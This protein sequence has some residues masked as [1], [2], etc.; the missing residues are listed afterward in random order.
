MFQAG[1]RNRFGHPAEEVLVRYRERG[2]AIVTS[3]ACGA[4]QWRADGLPAGTCERET[5][6][7]YWHHA[8][9]PSPH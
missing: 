6:R 8:M 2:I 7:R 4:W 5:A 9:A 3:P 1:Y